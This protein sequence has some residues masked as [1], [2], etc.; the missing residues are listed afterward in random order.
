MNK[1]IVLVLITI[2]LFL[3]LT[4]FAE[5]CYI[6]TGTDKDRE[7]TDNCFKVC[8][9]G[10]VPCGKAVMIMGSGH[11]D[12]D[13]LSATDPKGMTKEILHCQ[14]CHVFIMISEMINYLFVKVIPPITVLM[15]VIGGVMF[16]FG[17]GRPELLTR[18]K[19]LLKTVGIGLVLVYG[20]FMFVGLFLT[21]LGAT[22]MEPVKNVWS[23]D[24]IFTI[25]CP[26]KIPESIVPESIVP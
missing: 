2:G 11:C 1:S 6:A 19:S 12:S 15:L 4:S 10:F 24:R 22:D 14:L 25:K 3:P 5:S 20:A 17:G 18:A 16:Y 9:E 26:V 23:N 21:I 8:Y 7:P 13:I